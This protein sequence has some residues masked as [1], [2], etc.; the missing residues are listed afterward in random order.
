MRLLAGIVLY[1]PD[2]NR[3]RENI[4]SIEKQIDELVLI[5]NS[6][7]KDGSI[8][9]LFKQISPTLKHT[10]INN[11]GNK[12]IA[13]ALNQILNYAYLNGYEW[14]LTLD[15]DTVCPE[16]MI[17]AFTPFFGVDK[18]G[19]I[20]PKIVDRNFKYIN[21]ETGT[22]NYVDKCITSASLTSTNAWKDV[23]GFTDELFIDYVDF[24]YCFKLREK[25]YRILRVNTVSV[26]H[27]IGHAKT[28]KIF[29]K[30]ILV[31]N[32]PPI[33]NYYIVRNKLYCAY[34]YNDIID[35]RKEKKEILTFILRVLCFEG[36]KFS[37]FISCIK[38]LR[39]GKKMICERERKFDD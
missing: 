13:R 23:G 20:C 9:C 19:I 33:R 24:D 27:E 4:C 25:G 39:E 10:I 37:N 29:G 17:E 35:R 18:L 2:I 38:G 26:L 3:L 12:G 6:T 5:D 31:F 22:W 11:D 28:Y 15:Q 36:N 7:R 8:D 30:R 16:N 1:N 34:I 14:A 32:H 21:N